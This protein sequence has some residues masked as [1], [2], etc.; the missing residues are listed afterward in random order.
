[1]VNVLSETRVTVNQARTLPEHDS[2]AE[3]VRLGLFAKQKA[4]LPKYVYDDMGSILFEAICQL[5]EYYVTRAETEILQRYC[6]AII[7][8]VPGPLTL[9]EAGSGSATKTRLV[10]D[11]IL[12]RQ[13]SLQYVPMDISPETLAKSAKELTSTFPHLQVTAYAGDYFETFQLLKDLPTERKLVLFLGTSLGNFEPPAD[14][15]FLHMVRSILQPGE[16]V[17]LGLD[18]KKSAAILEPAYDDALGVTAAFNLNVLNRLNRE[19]GAHFDLRRFAHRAVYNQELGRVEMHLVS[20]CAQTVHVN[21]WDLDLHFAEGETIYTHS[22][23]KY[24][25]PQIH[26]LA[27]QADFACLHTWQDANNFFSLNLLVAQ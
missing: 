17:L 4:L 27:R 20:R 16:A 15:N 13:P 3:D 11:T 18:L 6:G 26:R 19:V 23:Y 10:I 22:S 14:L 2:F 24:D 5:P 7:D 12:Q 8:T 21:Q 9:I 25:Q 1:M